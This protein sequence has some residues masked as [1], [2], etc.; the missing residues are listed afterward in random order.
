MPRYSE[1]YFVQL[2]VVTNEFSPRLEHLLLPDISS[3]KRGRGNKG[4]RSS[5]KY[6]FRTPAT[7]LMSLGSMSIKGSSPVISHSP[8]LYIC[9]V[10][11]N[12]DTVLNKIQEIT[13]TVNRL[14]FDQD[15]FSLLNLQ[16]LLLII[17]IQSALNYSTDV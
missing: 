14:R 4:S 9:T 7:E 10:W 6:S 11:L 12:T 16:I 15:F 3:S 8:N 1:C 2:L 5:R 17:S 13:K